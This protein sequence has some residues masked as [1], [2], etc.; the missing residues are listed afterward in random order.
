MSDLT[1]FD[2]FEKDFTMAGREMDEFIATTVETHYI[3]NCT[4]QKKKTAKW[5]RLITAY[6][7]I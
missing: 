5:N 7:S 3:T 2:N 1:K 6:F 4:G